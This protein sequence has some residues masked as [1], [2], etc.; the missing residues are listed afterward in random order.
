VDRVG[1]IKQITLGKLGEDI[2]KDQ[3]IGT[4]SRLNPSK[5]S[6]NI[7]EP[8]EEVKK[9]TLRIE[10]RKT[11]LFANMRKGQL[12]RLKSTA[13]NQGSWLTVS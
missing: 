5:T 3:V 7:K 9:D 8:D 12:N 2:K 11:S 6:V 1:F 4:V 13:N 10:T